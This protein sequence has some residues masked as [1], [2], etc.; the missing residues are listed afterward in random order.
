MTPQMMIAITGKNY[1]KPAF[2][3]VISDANRA[4][5]AVSATGSRMGSAMGDAS[6]QTANL[7]AQFN[8]IGVMLASGQSPL[9]LAIQ[10]GTQISQVLGPMR[11]GAAVTALRTALM[12]LLS[13]VTLITVGSIAAGAAL[14][15]WLMS[16]N[17][18]ETATEAFERHRSELDSIVAGYAAAEASVRNYFDVVAKL[19]R[20]IASSD[21]NDAFAD[22]GAE[23]ESFRAK[24]ADFA[25]DTHF[26]KYGSE[27]ILS[28]QRL[29]KAFASGEL[30]AEEFYR[31]LDGVK[32]ELSLLER[33]GAG[34]PGSTNAM[35]DA[36][37]QGALRAAQFANSIAGIVAQSHALA[38]IAS[39]AD[40]SDVFKVNAGG[41][42]AAI[43]T[44][45][46]ATPELRSVQQMI[47]DT[48]AEG[49]E[50]P[51]ITSA[52]RD[53]L[54]AAKDTAL[55]A[56][57][58]QEARRGATSAANKQADA[59]A[60]VVAS[61][62][63]E[64]MLVGLSSREQEVLNNIRAAGVDAA[65]EQ[66][67][68]IRALTEEVHD[69]QAATEALQSAMEKVG[70]VGEDAIW[71]LAEAAKDGKIELSELLNIALQAVKALKGVDFGA[72][73]GGGNTWLSMLFGGGSG[74][75]QWGVQGGFAGYKGTFG[76]PS[77]DVGTNYHGGGPARVHDGEIIDLP[78]GSRV[79]TAEQSAALLAAA[80][81]ATPAVQVN[82][83]IINN[84]GVEISERRIE[85]GKGGVRQEIVL[86]RAVA[87]AIAKP[88]PA[89]KA[90]RS[91]GQLVRR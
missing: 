67:R 47:K 24:M 46:S 78:Q 49:M 8:D 88:G 70:A 74:A 41:V 27:A 73:G 14:V 76:I 33:V 36:W 65:S 32:D 80:R 58:E 45:K 20:S 66:G 38:G 91:T 16:A 3:S 11:A 31:A 25:N 12:S 48:Y 39:D 50:D 79:Y 17:D 51:L 23:V 4:A 56:V 13:P 37:Q 7:A 87:Q 68:A 21:L 61:L 57:A 83:T 28:M 89:Q 2:D 42:E 5:G 15:Q 26:A 60:G 72:V 43:E 59:Y 90:V 29:A 55:A 35:I 62:E 44:L 9:L 84:A 34:I 86:N 53:A 22:I 40:L 85:D 63:H 10:Q 30:T 18:I 54:T 6:F 64:R 1:T 19:P 71:G 82:T 75:G 77:Y 52:A 69:Q 81:P